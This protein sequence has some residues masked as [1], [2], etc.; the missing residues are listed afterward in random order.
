LRS[1][2]QCSRRAGSDAVTNRSGHRNTLR[3]PVDDCA[4]DCVTSA[5]AASLSDIRRRH[6][7]VITRRYDFGGEFCK[8]V[9]RG[10]LSKDE[11]AI[12]RARRINVKKA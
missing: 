2:R 5:H 12:G 11:R 8:G 9:L 6:P 10:M 4:K 7:D 1:G 3:L